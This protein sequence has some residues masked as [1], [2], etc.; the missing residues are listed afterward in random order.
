MLPVQDDGLKQ[1]TVQ[2]GDSGIILTL[3]PVYR[4]A[5]P[6]LTPADI[7]FFTADGQVDSD[8]PQQVTMSAEGTIVLTLVPSKTGPEHSDSLP[9]LVV[10]PTRKIPRLL[11]INPRY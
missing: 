11:E 2:R 10:I 9:G 7:H 6:F 8:Q 3:D 5:D 4:Q 1:I